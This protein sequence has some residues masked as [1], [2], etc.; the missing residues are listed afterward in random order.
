MANEIIKSSVDVTGIFDATTFDQLFVNARPLKASVREVS[1]VM[2]HPVEDGTVNS[3]HKID[4]PLSIEMTMLL[5]SSDF[6]SV[7]S[8]ISSVR[9]EATNLI[10]QT[11]VSSFSNMIIKSMPHEETADVQEGVTMV[12]SLEQVTVVSATAVISPL[13]PKNSTTVDAGKQQG[14]ETNETRKTSILAGLL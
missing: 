8:A 4:E 7:Y 13:F 12:L 9:K 5:T 2:S 1:S 10:V 3:D 11:R 6:N 14:T